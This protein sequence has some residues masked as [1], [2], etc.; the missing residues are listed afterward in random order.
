MR[1]VTLTLL[2]ISACTH[3]TKYVQGAPAHETVLEALATSTSKVYYRAPSKDEHALLRLLNG[4][5]LNAIDADMAIRLVAF[6]E[7]V[8]GTIRLGYA[9]AQ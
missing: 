7:P 9:S 3:H 8:T 4:S 5:I 2:V 1:L 6:S